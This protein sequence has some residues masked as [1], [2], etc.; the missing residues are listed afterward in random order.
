MSDEAG[1]RLETP[2][3][4]ILVLGAS[5]VV[6]HLPAIER[7]VRRR[8]GKG[9]ELLVVGGLGRSYGL[10]TRVLLRSLPAVV[11]SDVWRWLAHSPRRPLHALVTDVGNDVLYGEPVDR[12]LG[13]V[14]TC[15]AR[16][17]S[18][19]A[20]IA[21]MRLPMSRLARVTPSGYAWLRRM[22]YPTRRVPYAAAMERAGQLDDGLVRLGLAHGATT[23]AP[24]AAWYGLDP[25]HIRR[26]SGDKA[27]DS[28]VADLLRE[29]TRD[30][31]C[32]A[33]TA[34]AP[35]TAEAHQRST[36]RD[37]RAG[38]MNEL[39]TWALLRTRWPAACRFAGVPL[40]RRA[41]D[42]RDTISWPT[43]AT[44]PGGVVIRTF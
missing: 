1:S 36:R 21:V 16:L 24:E 15:L 32:G 29:P 31:P 22:F 33:T 38:W 34:G 37:L 39:R 42:D 20:R 44:L 9:V 8:L 30:S 13:W 4:R 10:P 17:E 3:A 40:V 26:R 19:N 41:G 43:A 2:Q 14:D 27:W 12:I 7:A 11:E 18:F 23:I 6:L 35:M 25:I 5:N 28:I